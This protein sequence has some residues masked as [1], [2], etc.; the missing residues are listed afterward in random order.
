M[1]ETPA[2][3]SASRRG[4]HLPSVS[5]KMAG[6]HKSLLLVLVMIGALL[7][8]W[9][10]T[11]A[12]QTLRADFLRR[13]QL[14]AATVNGDRVKELSG[15]ELD[16]T[17]PSY[18]WSKT[19]LASISQFHEHYRSAYLLGRRN[20]GSTFFF[21]NSHAREAAD[22]APP[23]KPFDGT[24]NG[25]GRAFA[26]R[27]AAVEG[28]YTDSRG[29]WISAFIP[30]HDQ[31]SAK[32][33][34][35]TPSEA[36]A[37]VRKAVDLFR[38]SGREHLLK[39]VN[40]PQ[41]AFRSRD[42]YAFVYDRGM[43]ML[44]HPVKP[45]LVGQN[46]LDKKDRA[47][48]RYFRKEIQAVALSPGKGWVSYDY[49]NPVSGTIEPKTSYAEGVDDLIMCAG[50]YSGSG[51]LLA[52]LG[53]DISVQDWN[54]QV[55]AQ[56]ALPVGLMFVIIAG[57]M[58]VLISASQRNISSRPVPILRRLLP[59]LATMMLLLMASG[60]AL[61]WQQHRQELTRTI[62][63]DMADVASDLR[64]ALDQQAAGLAATT[65]P[66]AA[67]PGVHKAL[68][69]RD[70][71]RLLADW[72]KVF[73]LLNRDN[74]LTHFYF[75]DRQR[76]CLLRLHKPEKSGDRIDRFTALEA[77]RTGKTASGIELGPLGTFTLRVVQPIFDQGTLIGYVELGKEIED[78]LQTLH[79]RSGIQIALT[80]YK[81]HLDRQTWEDGMRLLG[82]QA[83]W[84]RLSDQVVSYASQG[85]LPEAFAFWTQSSIGESRRRITDGKIAWNGKDWRIS[86]TPVQDASGNEVG[87]LLVMRDISSDKAAFAR[88]MTLGGTTGAILLILVLG[89]IYALLYRTDADIRA[90]QAALQ[91]NEARQNALIANISDVIGIIGAD[92]ILKYFSPNLEKW[93]GWRP[94][95]LIGTSGWS[96]VHPEDLERIQNNF[97]TLL[98]KEHATMTMEFRCVC[99]D[100]TYKPIELTAMNLIR[101]PFVRGILLNYHDI[102]ERKQ[103]AEAVRKEQVLN[104]AV[105]ASIPGTFYVISDSGRYVRWNGYQRDEIIGKPDA[106][107]TNTFAL[108][109]IHPEDRSLIQARI[110]NVLING[111]SET[112]EGRVLLRG[113]PD[114][115]WLLMTGQRM[116]IN[117]HAFLV[118]TGIDITERKRIDSERAE[119]LD[120]LQRLLDT[121]PSPIFYK[122]TTGVFR[123][124]NQAYLNFIGLTRD[125]VIGRVLRDILPADLAVEAHRLDEELLAQGGRQEHQLAIT[126]ADGVHQILVIKATYAHADGSIA[127]LVG[128]IV[129]LTERIKGEDALREAMIKAEVANR[130]KSQFLSTMSHEIRNPLHG[131]IGMASLL[132]RSRLDAAHMDMVKVI[133]SSSNGLLAVIG[134]VLDLA[135]IESG[136]LEL[137]S[138]DLEFRR[139]AEEI[140]GMFS[141]TVLTKGLNLVVTVN[142]QVPQLLR[143]DAVRLRQVLINLVGNAVKFTEHG[144]IRLA[145]DAIAFGPEYISIVCVVSDTGPGM[146]DSYLPQLFKPFS[147][148]DASMTRRHGGSGLGLAI[149][150]RLTDLM[151]GTLTVD[152]CLGSGSTFRFSVPLGLSGSPPASVDPDQLAPLANWIRPPLVLLVEDDATNRFTL[153]LMLTEIGC[154]VSLAQD[155]KEAIAAVSAN[156]FDLVLMDCQMPVCDGYTATRIIR[157]RL[158]S[159]PRRLLIIALS[160]NV[161]VEDRERCIASGMDGFLAKP[162]NFNDLLSCLKQWAGALLAPGNKA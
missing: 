47:G 76:T 2:L 14:L 74:H 88:L 137:E 120:F 157:E 15:A 146:P 124:C 68:N 94:Q 10:V 45:E 99:K 111:A 154:Q 145:I 13:A 78:T 105:I 98:E 106:E 52:V 53:L 92:E 57:V 113:G 19:Q 143:G 18:L 140:Q 55:A 128:V 39:Q 116:V 147:Q 139:L 118:G 70:P 100:G 95:D 131:I 86:S 112:V 150:K 21:L 107:V 16:T 28:P 29:T 42:L 133:Q 151:G 67:D 60:G 62:E 4:L 25:A 129:D 136:A 126:L 81:K 109:T 33:S 85:R 37:L 155:G 84:D 34:L 121:V 162:C 97:F 73:A 6:W 130:A 102:S 103:A 119:Q 8:W 3:S 20:D 158:P 104:Q 24:V 93:F 127:G 89:F 35:A 125:Q 48:G 101:E 117:D 148:A 134:D 59:S 71:I 82:R 132:A 96:T 159:T 90:Q 30:I 144:E 26:T 43:T 54:G 80:L 91:E 83:D 38:K 115:R 77:E 110:E 50:A 17:L 160:G 11:A 31:R 58:A 64:M 32:S 141:A 22:Y 123:G 40:D 36:Q 108:D 135:K 63:A 152:T 138:R 61:L 79:A 161:F 142:P 72:K 75:F 66:I 12:D 9:M 41:G 5:G 56:V 149:A 87:G 44:A 122:D 27:E 46:L 156:N 65:Q 7:T 23:G 69:E 153:H 1:P 114:F 51:A 49:E